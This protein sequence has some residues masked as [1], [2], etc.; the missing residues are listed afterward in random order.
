MR[1]GEAFVLGLVRALDDEDLA[2]PS[3]LPGWRRAHVV[4]HLARNA[5]A[6]GNLFTWAV[7]GEERPMY[8]SVEQRAEGIDA[9][10]EQAPDALRADVEAASSRLLATVATL[11]DAAWDAPVRTARGRTITGADVPWMRIRESWVHAVDLATGA[12]FD[13]IPAAVVDELLAEVAGGLARREGC[14]PMTLV[15]EGGARSWEL[16]PEAGRVV[17]SGPAPALLAWLIGRADGAGLETS[18]AGSALPVPPE[19]L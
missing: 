17:V 2:A 15:D 18:P 8:A 12:S 6:L 11:P 13:D 16:G 5:D 9:S 7:T 14:P 1:D 10:A 4:A 3:G 19:W